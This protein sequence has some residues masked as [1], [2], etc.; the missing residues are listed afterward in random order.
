MG[1][2]NADGFPRKDVLSGIRVGSVRLENLM[3]THF[4]F[5]A[6]A[7]VPEHSHPH[8]Q[9]TLM[10]EGEMEFTFCGET[11]RIRA[12][13]GCAVPPYAKH[14]VRAITDAKAVDCW[15]PIREDYIVSESKP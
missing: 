7:E 4:T 15:H 2:F 5:K 12:G 1:F 14:S 13:D 11:R 8:E 6:G 3:L 9:I 10:I